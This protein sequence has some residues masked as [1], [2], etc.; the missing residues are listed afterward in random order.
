LERLTLGYLAV[1]LTWFGG[2]LVAA[3]ANPV[4][5]SAGWCADDPTEG[6][7]QPFLVGAAALVGSWGLLCLVAWIFAFG[8]GWAGWIVL[9]DLVA[10]QLILQTNQLWWAAGMLAAPA[11]AAV[12][13]RPAPGPRGWSDYLKAGLAGLILVQLVVWTTLWLTG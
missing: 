4:V 6:L 8:A 7:C 9:A 13:T 12:V 1:L 11:L 10:L 5:R 2:G 3:G